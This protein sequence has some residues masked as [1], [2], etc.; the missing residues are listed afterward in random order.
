MITRKKKMKPKRQPCVPSLCRILLVGHLTHR[1]F[2]A[3]PSQTAARAAAFDW[4]SGYRCFPR[5]RPAKIF[6]WEDS[7]L[8]WGICIGNLARADA[9]AVH[10]KPVLGESWV[11]WLVSLNC[12]MSTMDNCGL[13]GLTSL[14]LWHRTLVNHKGQQIKQQEELW[15]LYIGVWR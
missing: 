13:K 8:S 9:R 2:T 14:L 3:P 12:L 7:L 1:S 15:V 11:R 5:T 10:V 6:P 4:G